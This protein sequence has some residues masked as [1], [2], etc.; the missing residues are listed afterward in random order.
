MGE[1]QIINNIKDAN[2]DPVLSNQILDYTNTSN[3][4]QFLNNINEV[5]DVKQNAINNKR[6][7][8][9][10]EYAILK[11]QKQ[12][13][14]LKK[15]IVV[16]CIALIGSVLFHTNL[17]PN[18]IYNGYLGIVFGIGF[19]IVAYD[20]FDIFMRNSY[21]FNQYDYEF[22]YTPPNTNS[23]TTQYNAIQLSNLPTICK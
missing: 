23:S 7:I 3:Y 1:P 5:K 8:E 18:S 4:T 10:N 21:D 19:I 15:I 22:I 6:H 12:S 16:C 9:V 13:L 2:N 17:I 11:Y 20:L 14:L